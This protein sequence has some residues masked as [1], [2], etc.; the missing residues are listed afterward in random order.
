[1]ASW[2]LLDWAGILIDFLFE[3]QNSVVSSISFYLFVFF[4]PLVYAILSIQKFMGIRWYW[5]IL[6]GAGAKVSV[7][8]VN[9]FYRLIIFLITFWTT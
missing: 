4:L 8:I 2:I 3:D 5:A 7:T 1:M 9:L 6:A